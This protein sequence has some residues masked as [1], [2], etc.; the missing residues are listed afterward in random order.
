M[1]NYSDMELWK[2]NFFLDSSDITIIF[3]GLEYRLN[4]QVLFVSETL[5]NLFTNG[6]KESFE[7][8][9]S[10]D[11]EEISIESW[12]IFLNYIYGE[13][14]DFYRTRFGLKITNKTIPTIDTLSE[15]DIL[16]LYA[17]KNYFDVRSLSIIDDKV[18]KI[19]RS[20]FKKG[21]I[22]DI[23]IFMNNIPSLYD[24][25]NEVFYGL[26]KEHIIKLI[27]YCTLDKSTNINNNETSS[28]ICNEIFNLAR[29]NFKIPDNLDNI[30]ELHD[31]LQQNKLFLSKSLSSEYRFDDPVVEDSLLN[32]L[33]LEY[34]N[35]N[36]DQLFKLVT[37]IVGR[38]AFH[39][40][41]SRQPKRNLNGTPN[42]LY[43][44]VQQSKFN[45]QNIDTRRKIDNNLLSFIISHHS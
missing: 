23:D 12:E 43:G 25:I 42:P 37:S 29:K 7:D 21:K 19:I 45:S 32:Y 31:Y 36:V 24:I 10:I 9:V 16:L 6:F 35:Y 33:L 1:A 18:K 3:N 14:I 2:E 41:T 11:V 8:T 26:D 13:H 30:Y 15:D 28:S 40:R 17:A 22:E 39:G 5:R 44:V 27:S 4:K 20:L 38:V 34:P